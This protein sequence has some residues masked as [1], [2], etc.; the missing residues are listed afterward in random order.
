ML[1]SREALQRL[2]D[3]LQT[4]I[5]EHMALARAE[6]RDDARKLGRDLAVGAAGVP[7]VAAGYLLLMVAVS[8]LLTLWLPA[9]AAFGI[10][11]LVNLGVGGGLTWVAVAKVS[12]RGAAMPRSSEELQRDKQ[13]LSSL[14][15]RQRH[16]G[17]GHAEARTKPL[18]AAPGHADLEGH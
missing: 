5:R 10:V 12:G 7:A 3:G 9:W 14:K 6:L 15:E 13:W 2:L 4:L 1:A 8:L 18:P 17:N 16:E 11:A